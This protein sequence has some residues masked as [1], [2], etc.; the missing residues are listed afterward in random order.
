MHRIELPLPA[1]VGTVN[2]YLFEG[3]E[4][5]LVDTGLKTDAS[6]AALKD[7]LSDLGY[8]IAD[9]E[10]LIITHG[11]PDHYGQGARIVEQS[12]A[13]VYGHPRTLRRVRDVGEW[14]RR[15]QDFQDVM[16][17]RAGA[18]ERAW[19]FLT[20]WLGAHTVCSESLPAGCAGIPLE[21]G[22]TIALGGQ[23]W[24]V[25]ELPGHADGLICLYQ[26]D[27]GRLLSSDLLIPERAYHVVLDPPV[28]AAQGRPRPVA[29]FLASLDRIEGLQ[30]GIVLPGHGHPSSD[31]G[32]I[33]AR[34]RTQCQE[35]RRQVLGA[36]GQR[37]TAFDVW[38]STHDSDRPA[39][40]R[41]GVLEV[42]SYLDYLR[43]EGR[44]TMEPGDQH[45]RYSSTAGAE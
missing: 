7:Q 19:L 3:D 44:A 9:L 27:S 37:M 10:R 43:D 26:E 11:H 23:D 12:G 15:L 40:L 21:D 38:E 5:T 25:L 13:R 29:D 28:G 36:L 30:A 45:D 1:T 41:Q 4:L 8:R 31:V 22:D 32:A 16:L 39:N 24:R 33:V 6:L 34:R 18:P 14:V 2:V 42:M 17:R 35:R 20:V